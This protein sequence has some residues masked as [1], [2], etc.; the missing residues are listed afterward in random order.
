MGPERGVFGP[1]A[2]NQVF[3]KLLGQAWIA[4]GIGLLW[5]DELYY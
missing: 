4:S 5:K 1:E 3:A 2:D